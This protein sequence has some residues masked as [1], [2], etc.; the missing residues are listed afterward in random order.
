M[1]VTWVICGCHMGVTW[2][3]C[4]CHMMVSVAHCGF[5]TSA[6]TDSSVYSSLL[7]RKGKPLRMMC[8]S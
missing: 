1:V 3:S 4:D 7:S 8:A 6:A 5:M 2:V